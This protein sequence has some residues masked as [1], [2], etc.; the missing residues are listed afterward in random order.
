MHAD[1]IAMVSC[2]Q[3]MVL[4]EQF[5]VMQEQTEATASSNTNRFHLLESELRGIWKRLKDAGENLLK[6]MAVDNPLK[7]VKSKLLVSTNSS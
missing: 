3:V 4:Q 1:I 6:L 2:S 7:P 5:S